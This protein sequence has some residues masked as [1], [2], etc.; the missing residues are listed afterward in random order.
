MIGQPRAVY[1]FANHSRTGPPLG[2]SP[3]VQCLGLVSSVSVQCLGPNKVIKSKN[4][5]RLAA[6]L[7][8]HIIEVF[9]L[10]VAFSDIASRIF[11]VTPAQNSGS[12]V[13]QGFQINF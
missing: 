10:N 11:H 3:A 5:R 1:D 8:L 6:G 7:N 12:Y 4:F 2:H 13:F 9:S